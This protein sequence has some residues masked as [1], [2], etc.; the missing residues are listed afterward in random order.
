MK[1]VVGV[2]LGMGVYLYHCKHPSVLQFVDFKF[3]AVSINTESGDVIYIVH[4]VVHK[5]K[6]FVDFNRRNSVKYQFPW[7]YRVFHY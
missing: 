6:E 2:Y 4:M 7:P 3:Q 5:M 1:R